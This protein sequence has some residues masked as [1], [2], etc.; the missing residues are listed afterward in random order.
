MPEATKILHLVAP[1]GNWEPFAHIAGLAAALREHGFSSAITA[2]D[3]SRLWELAEAVGVEAIEY[4]L[5]RSLNPLR[6]REL[7]KF[8]TETGAG[9]VHVHDG[10][11][12]AQ[13][14]RATMF[15]SN[16]RVVTTRYDLRT[17]IAGA[18]FGSGVGAV[19]CPSFAMAE[20]F[21]QRKAPED[22]LHVVLNGVSLAMAD[23][24]GEE[25]DSIRTRFRD[26]YC[27]EKEKPLFI[28][29]MSPLDETGHHADIIEA[30]PEIMAVLP[31]TH[32]FIM[33]EGSQRQELE[34]QVKITALEKDITFL[35]PDKAFH[36][37]LAG[38]DL[39]VAPARDDVS[40]FMVQAAMASGRAVVLRK[41]GCYA[42]LAEDGKTAVFADGDGA[43]AFREAMLGLLENRSRRE[44]IGRLAKAQAAKAFN[45]SELAGRVAEIYRQI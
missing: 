33:G 22:K 16:M 45:M 6:W 35:E 39:Y 8:V 42:E 34:R 4:T 31:Q 19:L 38:S 26:Q 2:P 17:P 13:L 28:V 41:S 30:M 15:M 3:H 23:R 10:G 21:K 40:G 36:R 24:A 25:R 1:D 20:A 32:L 27:P 37:L 14:S 12:A 11:A 43:V 18:E 7:G 44:H 5:E 9:I 29:N